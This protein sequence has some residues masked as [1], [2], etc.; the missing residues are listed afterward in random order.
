M[1][2]RLCAYAKLGLLK[3]M[4]L[5]KNH[6]IHV[7][8]APKN[9]VHAKMW[10]IAFYALRIELIHLSVDVQLANMNKKI[11]F[12]VYLANNHHV[13]LAGNDYFINY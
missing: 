1:I 7:N 3:Y 5:K 2:K 9:V 10:K 11:I 13:V 6:S 8:N 12:H 4:I